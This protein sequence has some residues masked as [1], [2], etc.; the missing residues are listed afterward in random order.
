MQLIV[1]H[2]NEMQYH[3]CAGVD[4]IALDGSKQTVTVI[5]E[6]DPVDIMKQLRKF[7]KNAQIVSVGPPKPDDSKKDDAEKKKDNPPHVRCTCSQGETWFI[8]GDG[9]YNPCSLL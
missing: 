1:C 4:S 3:V 6:A 2:V 9:Y 7:R 5:G 8:V